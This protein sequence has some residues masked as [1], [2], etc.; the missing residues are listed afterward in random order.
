MLC[1]C[2]RSFDEVPLDDHN[3][4]TISESYSTWPSE[5]GRASEATVLVS[6]IEEALERAQNFMDVLEREL[7][8]V[9]CQ[10]ESPSSSS[11]GSPSHE[12]SRQKQQAALLGL[13]ASQSGFLLALVDECMEELSCQ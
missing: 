8:S 2:P 5:N 10:S 7:D 12:S 3:F 11:S 4:A 6:R 13:I 9:K 1:S